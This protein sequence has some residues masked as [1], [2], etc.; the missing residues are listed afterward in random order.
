MQS[1]TSSNIDAVAAYFNA[2]NSDLDVIT[3]LA[4]RAVNSLEQQCEIVQGLI[5]KVQQLQALIADESFAGGVD[6]A[7]VWTAIDSIHENIERDMALLNTRQ[8]NALKDK[9]LSAEN[10]QMVCAHFQKAIVQF[11]LFYGAV[12]ELRW[13]FLEAEADSEDQEAYDSVGELLA[14]L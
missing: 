9:N 14:A 4:R 3:L 2:I 12:E 6:Y 7:H 11:K 8:R 10:E 5:S 13:E 1:H